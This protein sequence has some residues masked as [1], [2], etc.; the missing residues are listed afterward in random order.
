MSLVDLLRILGTY[1][2]RNEL[3]GLSAVCALLSNRQR[4]NVSLT[5]LQVMELQRA[6]AA[7]K[8]ASIEKQAAAA[9]Q[10]T[11][12]E[13]AAE[14]LNKTAPTPKQPSGTACIRTGCTAREAKDG[15]GDL[16]LDPQG[17]RRRHRHA[18]RFNQLLTYQCAYTY[19]I[20]PGAAIEFNGMRHHAWI[21]K[22]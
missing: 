15:N 3:A 9:V 8:L 7:Q 14:E 1:G 16:T 2:V 4:D 6:V 21:F 19:E 5:N 13:K 18:E 10:A 11:I 17:A 20:I 22:T 12:D